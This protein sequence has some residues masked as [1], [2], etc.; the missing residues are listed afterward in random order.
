MADVITRLKVESNEY[1]N[2]LK[3]ASQSLL[4]MQEA[5]RRTGA[6][7]AVAEKEEVKFAQSLGNMQTVARNAKGKLGE[8]TNALTEISIVYKR[9]TDEEK[10]GEFGRALNASIQQLTQRCKDAKTELDEVNKS[11]T[12]GTSKND[13]FG[14]IIEKVTGKLGL[15]IQQLGVLG[16]TL[17][18]ATAAAKVAKDAFFSNEEQ[19]DEWGRITASSE[20]IYKSFLD[21]L[22]TGDIS[23]FLSRINQIIGA[24]RDA[25]DALDNLAT[26][27]AFNQ[28]NVEKTRTGLTESIADYREGKGSKGDVK[29]AGEALKKELRDRAKMEADAYDAELKRL[30]K[31]RGVSYADL[32]NAMSGSYGNYQKLKSVQMTGERVNYNPAI[33]GGGT[34]VTKYAANDQERLGEALRRFND[35]ELQNLQAL[36]A[37]AQ[38]TQ[39]EI[40]SVDKQLTRVLSGG[41]K[42]GGSGSARTTTTTPD[43]KPEN[44]NTVVSKSM[45]ELEQ[46]QDTLK[47]VKNSMAPFGKT[48]EE[49]QTMNTYAQELQGRIDE[50]NGVLPEVKTQFTNALS[51]LQ[52]LEDEIK[53]VTASMENA[54]TPEDWAE[55]NEYLQGLKQRLAGFKGELDTNKPKVIGEKFS[56]G[57]GMANQ[58]LGGV[59]SITDGLKNLGV[60]FGEGFEKFMGKIDGV[61]QVLNGIN[62]IIGVINSARDTA[63]QYTMVTLMTTL[64]ARSMIP[65]FANGGFT[66]A[67]NGIITGSHFS[68][69]VQPLMVNAGEAVINQADQAALFR[70]IKEGNFGGGSIQSVGIRGTDLLL[71]LNNELRS[72]GRATL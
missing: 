41:G 67:A 39:T 3:R 71:V 58:A 26:Y 57:L 20:S 16:V 5:A 70:A 54:A 63:Y 8:M 55:M 34:T 7:M 64:T 45:T 17:G 27:N 31:E 32:K 1:D 18:T 72:R 37:Q 13:A 24:A 48:S 60:E 12:D 50:L 46:L 44:V 33:M 14:D 61:M 25:Y 42:S 23:G 68:S 35:T 9:M 19:L 36:G 2:K 4:S 40:A 43:V 22:N 65:F 47:L 52:L 30:A 11:V 21:A 56:N 15:N 69:D 38:R 59:K 29:K 49:W 66:H 10:K 62:T 28:I 6:S 53:M 51:P